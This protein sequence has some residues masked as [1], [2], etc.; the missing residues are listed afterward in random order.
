VDGFTYLTR[1]SSAKSVGTGQK[2]GAAF[3][4]VKWRR[5]GTI[6]KTDTQ[7][8]SQRIPQDGAEFSDRQLTGGYYLRR[9]EAAVESGAA[10]SATC[11]RK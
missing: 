8:N 9:P 10:S 3:E 4:R 6:D 5:Q 1:T 2:Q 7:A 11:R